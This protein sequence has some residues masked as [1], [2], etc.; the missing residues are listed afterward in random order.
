MGSNWSHLYNKTDWEVDWN[1]VGS[2]EHW[3][4]EKFMPIVWL[5]RSYW[6]TQ[7]AFRTTCE[8][9]DL[10]VPIPHRKVEN[11]L[12]ESSDRRGCLSSQ[13]DGKWL[14]VRIFLFDFKPEDILERIWAPLE[15]LHRLD[16]LRVMF[17]FPMLAST[18]TM[19]QYNWHDEMCT[20]HC[21]LDS[22]CN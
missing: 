10:D 4:T 5:V 15:D 21:N 11:L 12:A 17:A 7:I 22:V 9:H 16:V 8:E 18:V 6:R 19:M 1:N 14:A 2:I 13:M 20:H 3:C